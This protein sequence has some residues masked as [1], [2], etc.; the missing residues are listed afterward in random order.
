MGSVAVY[1]GIAHPCT[2]T[3]VVSMSII[4]SFSMASSSGVSL[5][6]RFGCGSAM[7]RFRVS[8]FSWKTHTVH[9][10]SLKCWFKSAWVRHKYRVIFH[11]VTLSIQFERVS[12]C[13]LR[14]FWLTVALLAFAWFPVRWQS[15][16]VNASYQG[17]ACSTEHPFSLDNVDNIRHTFAISAG[18][19]LQRGWLVL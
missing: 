2:D 19:R 16:I 7:E 13:I 15:H 8:S 6:L 11:S 9:T 3:G 14:A 10:V 12:T 5:L 4:K 17:S 18:Q 1:R